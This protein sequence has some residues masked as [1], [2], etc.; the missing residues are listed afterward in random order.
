VDILSKIYHWFRKQD[1]NILKFFIALLFLDVII[2]PGNLMLHLKYVLFVIVIVLWIP[3][4]MSEKLIL[5]KQLWLAVIFIAVFM[6]LYGLS[7]GFVN[8]IMHNTPIENIT[9]FNSFFF[10]LLVVVTVHQKIELRRYF[11][12]AVWAVVIITIGSYL[13]MLIDKRF[14]G[15]LYEYF[16][17]DKQTAIY[18]LRKYGDNIFLMIFY[19]TSPLL[20]FPLS[21]YLY[22]VFITKRNKNNLLHGLFILLIATTLFLSGT[23]ANLLSLFLIILFYISAMVFKKSRHW[24]VLLVSL[25]ILLFVMSLPWLQNMLLSRHEASNAIKFGY[26]ASYASYFSDHI[27]SLFAGQ[28][29]GGSFYAASIH[30]MTSVTELTYLELIRVWG[31]PVTI[32]FLGVL[33]LPTIAELR[34]NKFTHLFIAY[35][36]FLFIAGTNPLLMSSTG[37]L[38]LVYVFSS[39]FGNTENNLSLTEKLRLNRTEKAG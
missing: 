20:I 17:V 5:S 2:D 21:Y 34:A 30:Q 19:K 37:M 15:V 16:V 12:Y 24:F 9:Y 11:N 32:L 25:F 4:V 3:L 29:I 7:A 8:H 10:F 38:V 28:G 6:P 27:L 26:F 39:T 1:A 13:F 35:L 22:Q 14:F 33:I 18:G 31:I 23:R 36:A